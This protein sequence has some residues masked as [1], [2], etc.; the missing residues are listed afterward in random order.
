MRALI[1][2]DQDGGWEALYCE[3]ELIDEGH[4]IGEGDREFI[5]KAGIEHGFSPNDIQ[6]A[7]L[8]DKDEEYAMSHGNMPKNIL[9]Y[10][11]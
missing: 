5:W 6:Y 9:K 7:T 11:K 1:L 2:S 3:G 4:H 8:D 10:Y